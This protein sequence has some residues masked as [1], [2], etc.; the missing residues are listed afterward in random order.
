MTVCFMQGGV[1]STIDARASANERLDAVLADVQALL[2][3]TR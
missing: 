1:Q 3:K 2:G